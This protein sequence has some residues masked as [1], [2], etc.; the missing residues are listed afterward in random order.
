MV[1]HASLPPYTVPLKLSSISN[2]KWNGK[3]NSG[4]SPIYCNVK[5][6]FQSNLRTMFVNKKDIVWNERNSHTSFLD[7]FARS[8]SYRSP[9]LKQNHSHEFF[10]MI[11]V[12]RSIWGTVCF[13][14]KGQL[15]HKQITIDVRSSLWGQLSFL[16]HL[17]HIMRNQL[18]STTILSLIKE[19]ICKE[20]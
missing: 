11:L 6:S 7:L 1:G 9:S 12:D 19:E 2:C 3:R 13:L 17:W 16:Q 10:R 15:I 20:N 4:R 5:F 14:S 18:F 8:I